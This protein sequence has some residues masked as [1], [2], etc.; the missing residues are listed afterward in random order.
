MNQA[1]NGKDRATGTEDLAEELD[2]LRGVQLGRLTSSCWR[3]TVMV[4]LPTA[5][6]LRTHSTSP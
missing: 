6:R 4:A 1:P 3:W 2:A 5:R